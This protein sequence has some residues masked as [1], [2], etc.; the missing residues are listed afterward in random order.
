VWQTGT[1]V[2]QEPAA[3]VFREKMEAKEYLDDRGSRFF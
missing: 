1:N 2:L 3:S